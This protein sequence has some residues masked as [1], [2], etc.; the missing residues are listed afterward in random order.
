MGSISLS[1][2]GFCRFF[3]VKMCLIPNFKNIKATLLIN[4]GLKSL[5][6]NSSI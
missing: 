3:K 1:F 6:G 4:E 2:L 5:K